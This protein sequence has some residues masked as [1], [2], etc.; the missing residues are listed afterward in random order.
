MFSRNLGEYETSSGEVIVRD[1]EKEKEV[2]EYL[3]ECGV[4]YDIMD[5]VP[6]R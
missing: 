4:A 6:E 3:N 1:R 5:Q 2:E